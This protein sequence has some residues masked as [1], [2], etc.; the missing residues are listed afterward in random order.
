MQQLKALHMFYLSLPPKL[1]ELVAKKLIQDLNDTS[2]FNKKIKTDI[3][4][5]LIE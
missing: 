3:T 5:R 2:S 4:N 1:R